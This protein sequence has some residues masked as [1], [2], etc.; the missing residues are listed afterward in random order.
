MAKK[1]RKKKRKPPSDPT[2]SEIR[3]MC[4]EIQTEWSERTRRTRAGQQALELPWALPGIPIAK[5]HLA[6]PPPVY[7]P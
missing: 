6:P 2:P 1:K 7:D 3:A 4:L 5:S